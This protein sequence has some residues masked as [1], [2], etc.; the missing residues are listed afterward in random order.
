MKITSTNLKILLM[1]KTHH[2]IY[3]IARKVNCLWLLFKRDNPDLLQ[4]WSSVPK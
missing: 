1:I 2:I 4:D 3:H